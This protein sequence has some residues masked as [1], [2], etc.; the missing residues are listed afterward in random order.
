[1]VYYKY[2]YNKIAENEPH[3]GKRKQETVWPIMRIH[4]QIS[5]NN[6]NIVVMYMKC[7]IKKK[8]LLKKF[9]IIV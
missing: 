4:N 7:I 5:Y 6:I 9:M 3:E 2:I 8:K 1:M